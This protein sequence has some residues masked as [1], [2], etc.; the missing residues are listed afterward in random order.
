MGEQL[1]LA[2]VDLAFLVPGSRLRL[3]ATAV[4]EVTLSRTPC[5]RFAH[6]QGTSIESAEGKL[7]VMAR[8]V[9]GGEIAVGDLAYLSAV[10]GTV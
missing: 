8:V 4:I 1:V 3:G 5:D 7:G 2:G 9:V 6:I 10:S